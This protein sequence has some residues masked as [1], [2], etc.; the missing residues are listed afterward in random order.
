VSRLGKDRK[1]SPS[2]TN[3]ETTMS[4]EPAW[5]KSHPNMTYLVDTDSSSSG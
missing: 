4:T 5:G 3:A 2:E 1:I